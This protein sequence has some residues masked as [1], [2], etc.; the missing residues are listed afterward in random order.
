MNRG[1]LITGLI[2]L[3]GMI[4]S[5][6]EETP[7]LSKKKKRVEYQKKI[8]EALK[9]GNVKKASAIRAEMYKMVRE[10]LHGDDIEL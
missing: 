2:V 10:E 1:F 7:L 9:E 5:K 3:L 4:Y 6:H 8:H